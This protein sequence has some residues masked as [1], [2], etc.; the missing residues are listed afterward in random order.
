MESN[1]Y[2]I[3]IALLYYNGPLLHYN[4]PHSNTSSRALIRSQLV[5]CSLCL[6]QARAGP[7][8]HIALATC[9][10]CVRTLYRTAWKELLCSL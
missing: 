2:Y 4:T 10:H 3:I 5:S 1:Y 8:N 9:F 6:F 7:G